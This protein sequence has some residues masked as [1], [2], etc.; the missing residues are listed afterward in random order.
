MIVALGKCNNNQR[1]ELVALFLPQVRIPTLIT[2][3]VID[4]GGI[5]TENIHGAA[6]LNLLL[7]FFIF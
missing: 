2:E 6:Q 4:Q 1:F 3:A 5:L 7:S